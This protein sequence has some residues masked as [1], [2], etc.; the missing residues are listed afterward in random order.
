MTTKIDIDQAK[1]SKHTVLC[2]Q[3][4]MASLAYSYGAN[5]QLNQNIDK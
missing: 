3:L 5:T 4:T 1:E 2:L